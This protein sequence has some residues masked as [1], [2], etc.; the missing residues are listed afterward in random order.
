MSYLA[1]DTA[2]VKASIARLKA[3]FPELADDAELALD[4]YEGE[5]DLYRVL[6]RIVR[7]RQEKLAMLDGLKAYIGDLSERKARSERSADALKA[8]AQDLMDAAD[9]DKITLPEATLFTTQPRES[10]NVTD[11]EALPQGFFDTRRI[12]DKTALKAALMAG[13]TIPGAELQLGL[14]GLTI[15][16]K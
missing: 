14:A 10:V 4:T 15:R 12:A 16:V 2:N 13:E 7:Q 11:V 6:S 3:A 9:Q 1:I 8:L 5:T